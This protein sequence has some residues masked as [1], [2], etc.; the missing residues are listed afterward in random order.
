MTE[1]TLPTKADTQASETLVIQPTR[2][3]G[4]L[5]LRDLWRYREL[6]YFLT[7]RDI[8][9]RYKQTLLG[10]AWAIIQ[11]LLQMIVFNFLFGNLAE[12]PTDG[13]PRPVFTYSALLVWNL[14]S[15][16]LS[17]AGRSLVAN[18][19]M[20]TKVYFPRLLIPLSS[21]L[22]GI[23]DFAIAFVI[24]LGMMFYYE[25]TPTVSIWTL[26]L[27]L[28]LA[29]VTALGIGLW[30]SALNVNYRDIR[31]IMP[32]LTQF[33]LLASPVAYPLS[34]ISDTWRWLYSLNPMVAVV[35]GFRWALV[36]QG[37]TYDAMPLLWISILSSLVLLISGLFYFRRM[38][39]TFADMV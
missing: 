10:A 31:Y 33:W 3:L 6:A 26:P 39:R 35:E 21:V 24:L 30:L 23:V 9:V 14:F 1:T 18:R 13:I 5:N 22:G 4:S 16:A 17:D 20:I 38:E 28:L 15:K 12:I 27:F 25:I 7:W 29:L 11:P 34:E 32:F 36:G 19:N 8:K 37:S 2:G